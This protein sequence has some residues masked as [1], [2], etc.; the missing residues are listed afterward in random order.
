MAVNELSR[1][2]RPL[3]LVRALADDHERRVAVVALDPVVGARPGR[4]VQGERRGGQ[5]LR[6]LRRE[7]LRHPR[8]E[9]ASLGAVLHARRPVGEEARRVEPGRHVRERRRRRVGRSGQM[10]ERVVVRG[11][12]DADGARGDVDPARLEAAHH[13]CEAA[14]LDASDEVRHG[15]H[16][17]LEEELRGVHALIAEL[18]DGL[19]DPEAGV[20]F[21]DDEAGHPAVARLGLRIRQREER[22][23][24]ALAAVG[25]EHLRPRDDVVASRAARHGAD[26]LHVRPGV[27]LR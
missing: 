7:E 3:D 6:R 18:R 4:A 16:A 9:V 8:F 14:P 27:R 12:G 20:A 22:E 23:R 24:V 15:H 1:D 25:H 11:L 10:R 17:I 2:Q 13:L 19:D 5:R 21:L 26:R